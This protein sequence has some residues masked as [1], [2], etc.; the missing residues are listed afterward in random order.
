MSGW[1]FFFAL[2]IARRRLV[3]ARWHGFFIMYEAG[4]RGDGTAGERGTVP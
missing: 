4:K 1:I 3:R 2:R